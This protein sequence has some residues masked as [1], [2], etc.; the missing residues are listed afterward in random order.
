MSNRACPNTKRAFNTWFKSHEWW[1]EDDACERLL[2][3]Y[4]NLA[5][6]IDAVDVEWC[7]DTVI[8]VM[9]NEYGE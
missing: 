8:S 4:F 2:P 7:M 3:I 6:T 5:E 1:H 9:R